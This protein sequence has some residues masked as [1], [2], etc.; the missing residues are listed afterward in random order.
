MPL[1][2]KSNLDPEFWARLRLTIRSYMDRT[3]EKDRELAPKLALQPSTLNNF[4]NEHST[5]MDGHA[6]ALACTIMNLSC[7]GTQI[8]RLSQFDNGQP[9]EAP[10]Q[11]LVLEFDDAFEIKPG[12]DRPTL[13]LRKPPARDTTVRLLVKRV[14]DGA[15]VRRNG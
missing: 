14:H 15:S 7:D 6:V 13:I 4:L 8:G 12:A 5:K 3:G 1:P 9:S 10:S 2:P 11:Q